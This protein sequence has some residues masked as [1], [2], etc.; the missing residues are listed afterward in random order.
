VPSIQ[1]YSALIA[2]GVNLQ[3]GD[4]AD[5]LGVRCVDF[6]PG[7]FTGAGHTMPHRQFPH[8]CPCVNGL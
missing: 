8:C 4:A 6:G 1:M 5:G 2:I 7:G 3:F